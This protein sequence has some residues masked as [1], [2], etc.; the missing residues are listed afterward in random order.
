MI[1][2]S[3]KP[4]RKPKDSKKKKEL[5]E[6]WSELLGKWD[7]ESV[8]GRSVRPVGTQSKTSVVPPY[9]RTVFDTAPSVDTGVGV[10][11]KEE[12]QQYTGEN[13]IGIGQLHKS[14][15]IPVFKQEDA[16]DLAKMRR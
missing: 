5:R 9:R 10:A 3:T 15:A 13:M 16:E 14:N 11:A 12:P 4:T 2:V 8:S 6:S 7:R 1:Y